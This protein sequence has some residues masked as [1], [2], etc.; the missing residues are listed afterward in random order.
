MK[1]LLFLSFLAT[2][3][4]FTACNKDDD[5]TEHEHTETEFDYHAHIISPTD[6]SVVTMGEMMN[7]KVEFESHA[8][9]TVH[10]I[11][12]RIYK[13]DDGI[14]I[15]NSGADHV[16]A[17]TGEYE[18]T[19]DMPLSETDGFAGHTDYELE[20]KVWGHESGEGEA[21]EV[22]GFHVHE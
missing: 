5:G 20:A 18:F 9:E 13:K 12:V 7:V 15:Y 2:A 16:H 17:E 11:S 22:V 21:I 8:G 14:E 4:L 10:H 19:L 6:G 3:F 1:N